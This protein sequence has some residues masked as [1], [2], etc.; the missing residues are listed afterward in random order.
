MSEMIDLTEAWLD[1]KETCA[2]NKCK[3]V[4]KGNIAKVAQGIIK[5]KIDSLPSNIVSTWQPYLKNVSDFSVFNEVEVMLYKQDKIKGRP[6]KDYIFEDIGKRAGGFGKNVTG[7]LMITLKHLFQKT[8]V[9]DLVVKASDDKDNNPNAEED[10]ARQPE[11]L[12]DEED[13]TIQGNDEK[14][15]D[16]IVSNLVRK[17]IW[18]KWDD[19]IRLG[20]FCMMNS[21]PLSNPDIQPLFKRKKSALADAIPNAGQI[22]KDALVKL[23]IVHRKDYMIILKTIV[24]QELDD[25]FMARKEQYAPVFEY[26]KKK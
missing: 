6:F 21:I 19:D 14:S 5:R 7:Y 17:I 23:G 1:W 16:E 13:S 22:M 8:L 4:N 10:R 24:M 9:N 3:P 26:I 15:I 18:E 2:I 11:E 12:I 25:Y 20:F